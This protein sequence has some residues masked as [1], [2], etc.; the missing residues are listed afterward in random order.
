ML[1]N[2]VNSLRSKRPE[3]TVWHGRHADIWGDPDARGYGW[4]CGH[5]GRNASQQPY[6]EAAETAARKHAATH[7]GVNVEP[8]K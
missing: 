1:K 5:C 6:A 4:Y 3:P 2:L 8:W 7:S